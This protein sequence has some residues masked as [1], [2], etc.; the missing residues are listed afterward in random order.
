MIGAKWFGG[1]FCKGRET[2]IFFKGLAFT[3]ACFGF[4]LLKLCVVLSEGEVFFEIFLPTT[5]RNYYN[6]L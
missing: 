1:V 4:V 2:D 3:G 6:K 5:H